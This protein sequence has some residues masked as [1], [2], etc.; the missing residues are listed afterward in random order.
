MD[1]PLF[2]A[3]MD[4]GALGLSAGF[5]GWLY[6]KMQHRL[7]DLVEKFQ[8]QITELSERGDKKEGEIRDRYDKVI[9]TYNSERD[10]LLQQIATQLTNNVSALHDISE[11]LD[12]I[13]EER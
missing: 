3:L 13:M 12:R 1:G 7:D 6:V 10:V 9:A 5:I 4:F 8:A 2:D 11:K